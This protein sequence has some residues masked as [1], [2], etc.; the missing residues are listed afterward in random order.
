MLKGRILQVRHCRLR[1]TSLDLTLSQQTYVVCSHFLFT[2]ALLSLYHLPKADTQIHDGGFF[3]ACEYFG[4]T[5]DNS[6]PPT[7]FYLFI[8]YYYYGSGDQL[9]HTNST[10]LDQNQSQWL[11]ELRRLIDKILKQDL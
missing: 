2:V 8:Y 5:F 3:L 1:F 10:P 6:F 11:S 7:P 4:R 9:A